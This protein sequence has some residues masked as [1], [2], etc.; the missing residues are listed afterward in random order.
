[1]F[2][3]EEKHPRAFVDQ[4]VCLLSMEHRLTRQ[5]VIIPYQVRKQQE[6]LCIIILEKVKDTLQP[7]QILNK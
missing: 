1:M 5:Q 7:A 2:F 4:A 6:D 3:S